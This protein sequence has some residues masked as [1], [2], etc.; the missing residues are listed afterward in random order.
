MTATL[1]HRSVVEL[2]QR[3]VVFAAI[4]ALALCGLLLGLRLGNGASPGTSFQTPAVTAPS[5]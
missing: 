5:P 4:V 1:H 2:D 3:L